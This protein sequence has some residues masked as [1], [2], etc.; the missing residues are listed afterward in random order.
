LTT[1]DVDLTPEQPDQVVA[2]IAALLAPPAPAADPWWR[3][4]LD[5][6]LEP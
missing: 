5:E 3:A 2:A 6:S 4:G 1:I